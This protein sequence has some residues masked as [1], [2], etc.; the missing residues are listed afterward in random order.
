[1]R[2]IRLRFV[3]FGVTS[4]PAVMH[5]IHRRPWLLIA[6]GAWSSA[7]RDPAAKCSSYRSQSHIFIQNRNFSLSHLHSTPPLGVFRS[8]YCHA[9]CCGKTRMVWPP[10]GE[11]FLKICYSF[12]QN[13]RTWKT[14]RQTPHDD[15]GRACIASRGK[16][17]RKWRLA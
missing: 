11:E 6:R 9:V 10:D 12:S 15:I 5:T 8:K 17:W 16:N 7:T 3:V 14:H 1:M 4:S 13:V 2:A